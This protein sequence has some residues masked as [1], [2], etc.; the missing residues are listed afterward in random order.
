MFDLGW[1]EFLII[2]LVLLVVIGPKELPVAL[3]W[4]FN[5]IKKIKKISNQFISGLESIGDEKDIDGIKKSIKKIK[6]SDFGTEIKEDVMKIKK[7][8]SDDDK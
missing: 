7:I 1:Q 2:S 4:F 8:I 5:S 6:D 3:N